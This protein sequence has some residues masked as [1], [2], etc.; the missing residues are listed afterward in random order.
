MPVHKVAAKDAAG[1]KKAAGM[2][3]KAALKAMAPARRALL[4]QKGLAGKELGGRAGGR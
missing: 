2:K 1:L 3:K 4:R